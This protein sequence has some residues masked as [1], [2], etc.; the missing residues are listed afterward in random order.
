M[1][2]D[3]TSYI[4]TSHPLVKLQIENKGHYTASQEVWD[5]VVAEFAWMDLRTIRSYVLELTGEPSLRGESVFANM[6]TITEY[7]ASRPGKS[8]DELTLCWCG[9]PAFVS[10]PSWDQSAPVARPQQ[11]ASGA[12]LC[13]PTT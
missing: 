11:P 2:Y 5:E 4:V 1:S 6:V 12:L 3:D 10:V 7:R 8:W 13:V 9:R